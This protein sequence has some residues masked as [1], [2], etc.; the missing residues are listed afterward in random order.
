MYDMV[1]I[2]AAYLAA[3]FLSGLEPADRSAGNRTRFALNF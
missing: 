1:I 2:A 3:I